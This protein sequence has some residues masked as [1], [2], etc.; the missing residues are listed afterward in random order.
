MTILFYY[1]LIVNTLAFAITGYDKY[2]AK[3][4]KRRI[5]EKTLLSIVAFGGTIGV[6]IAMLFFRHKTSKSS[7]LWKYFGILLLQIFIGWLYI[8]N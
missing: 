5:P 7:F 2:L 6:G 3:A 8:N 1:F 4:H